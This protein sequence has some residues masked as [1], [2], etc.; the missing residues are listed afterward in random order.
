[1]LEVILD[2][3]VSQPSGAVIGKNLQLALWGDE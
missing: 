3:I 1:M 2:Y